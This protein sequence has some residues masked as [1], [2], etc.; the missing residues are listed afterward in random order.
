MYR[1]TKGW[2]AKGSDFESRQEQDFSCLSVV[3]TGSGAHPVS[4]PMGI[5]G[6]SP[7]YSGQVVK[8]TTH[9][10]LEARSRIH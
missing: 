2:T 6:F 9:L 1:L 4:Y 3:Q 5:G 7:G 10:Q 8:L